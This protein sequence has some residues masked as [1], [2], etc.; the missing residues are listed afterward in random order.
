VAVAGETTAAA[1]RRLALAAAG[2]G[3]AMRPSGSRH[4]SE[5]RDTDLVETV[6]SLLAGRS[7]ATAESCTAGRVAA[8][9]AAAEG[10]ADFFRGGLVAYQVPVKQR[11]LGVTSTKVLNLRTAEEMAA[12]AAELLDASVTVATTGL[13]G[14][15]PIDGVPGGTVFIGTCVDGVTRSVR[16]WFPGDAEGVCA[17]A[18]RQAL[19][20]L[21]HALRAGAPRDQGALAGGES[22]G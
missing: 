13:A 19:R 18:T 11:L 1:A 7:V 6:S 3:G 12:G 4:R 8:A 10:A 16:H 22:S 14:G 2:Y 5:Q 15:E 20:D 21:A 17:A 9:L